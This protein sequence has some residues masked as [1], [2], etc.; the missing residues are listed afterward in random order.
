MTT[1]APTIR[2]VSPYSFRWV[3]IG[4][5]AFLGALAGALQLWTGTFVPPLEDIEPLGLDSWRLPAVWLFVSVALPSSVALLA[6]VRR[7]RRTPDA[8]LVAS[9]L[10]LVEV[11]VQIPFV[12]PSVLQ[13][14]MGTIAVLLAALAWTARRRGTWQTS[15]T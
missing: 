12:G 4:L 3:F 11:T 8:V 9:A 1:I 14:V 6:A 13:A 5:E 2:P 15:R 10:L 7:H